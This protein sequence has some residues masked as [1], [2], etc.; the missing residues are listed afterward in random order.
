VKVTQE[1]AMK[2]Q[3]GV[4]EYICLCTMS[5]WVVNATPQPPYC[6]ERDLVIT[7]QQVRWAPRPRWTDAEN[8]AQPGFDPRT[9]THVALMIQVR[10]LIN[11]DLQN[12]KGITVYDKYLWDCSRLKRIPGKYL[13]TGHREQK[14][15][16]EDKMLILH[17]YQYLFIY[18]FVYLFIYLTVLSIYQITYHSYLN[19]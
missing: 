19:Y 5:G 12:S 13:P 8:L 16:H 1:Q 17:I 6:R 2:G 14:I 7:A 10:M 18:L 4:Q 9:L 3:C 15:L 11:A